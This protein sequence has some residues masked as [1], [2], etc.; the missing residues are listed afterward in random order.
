MS[1]RESADELRQLLERIWD[2]DPA[3]KR[4]VLN[5]PKIWGLLERWVRETDETL[6]ELEA[7]IGELETKQEL[8]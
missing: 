2:S 4:T 1:N 7:R 3:F 5:G 6:A 8:S